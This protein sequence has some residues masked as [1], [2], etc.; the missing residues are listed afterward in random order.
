MTFLEKIENI[1]ATVDIDNTNKFY[2]T[3]TQFVDDCSC[4]DCAFYQKDF[5][6]T[7]LSI[8]KI[9]KQFGVDLTKSIDTESDPEGLWVVMDKGMMVFCHSSYKLIGN[10]LNLE[11]NNNE[12]FETIEDEFRTTIQFY[13]NKNNSITTFLTI[14]NLNDK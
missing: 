13:K 8:F 10:F 12:T 14:E 2:V 1:K 9:L 3:Q 7:P 6:K 11:N 5:L 4:E